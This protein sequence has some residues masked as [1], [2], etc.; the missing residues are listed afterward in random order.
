MEKREQ[1][2]FK[3]EAY[4]EFESLANNYLSD[5]LGRDD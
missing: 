3:Y 1:T 5:I 2:A 4:S